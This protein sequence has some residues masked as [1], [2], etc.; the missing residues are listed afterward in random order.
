MFAAKA[1]LR[2]HMIRTHRS[3]HLSN[4]TITAYKRP[5]CVSMVDV[6]VDAPTNHTT[7]LNYGLLPLLVVELT[8][9]HC[10]AEPPP[11]HPAFPAGHQVTPAPS[12]Q[13]PGKQAQW[14]ERKESWRRF[15]LVMFKNTS[16]KN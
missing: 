8:T 1:D 16:F 10:P 6:A 13:Q 7:A 15:L 11:G 12:T 5:A 14:G 3:T 2:K 9:V 4:T